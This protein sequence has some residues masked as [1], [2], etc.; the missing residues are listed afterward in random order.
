MKVKTKPEKKTTVKKIVVKNVAPV[1]RAAEK[2]I[3][4]SDRMTSEELAEQLGL[5]PARIS[6][7]KKDGIIK[8]LPSNS[9]KEGDVYLGSETWEPLAR[10]YCGIRGSKET[11]DS[12]K[13]KDAILKVKLKK[14]SLE[15]AQLEGTL[16]KAE[17]IER[18]IGAGLSRLR[19]QLLA[20]P[21]GV[22]PLIKDRDNVNE[23]AEIINERIYRA[24]LEVATIDV[25]KMMAEEEG[26]RAEET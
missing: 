20:I 18:V 19:I 26:L 5:T 6:Q 22:A 21:L 23:I 14:E 11:E 25:K 17:D 7:L 1:K 13:T 2:K 3:K 10:Y 8:P 16:H 24:L 9:R 12:A 15:L 4:D